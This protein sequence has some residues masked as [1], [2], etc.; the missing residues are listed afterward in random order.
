MAHWQEILSQPNI[1]NAIR[2]KEWGPSCWKFLDCLVFSYPLNPTEEQQAA[3]ASF[4]HS[5]KNVL[6]CYSCRVDFTR[7]M[8]KQPIESHLHSR[9]ALAR[10]LHEQHNN[11]NRKLGTPTISFEQYVLKFG[12]QPEPPQMGGSV[13]P[14]PSLSTTVLLLV[15]LGII[16]V[17]GGVFYLSA[18]RRKK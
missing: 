14:P 4:F 17:V 15:L 12:K 5:L 8:E 6:P 13:T 10:W 11:V 9:E 1:G 7:M 18:T 3:M 16:T 2:P